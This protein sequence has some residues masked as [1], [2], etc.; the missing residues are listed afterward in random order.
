[1][2]SPFSFSPAVPKELRTLIWLLVGVSLGAALLDP[3]FEEWLQV[4]GPQRLLSLSWGSLRSGFIWQPVTYLFVLQESGALDLIVFIHLFFSAYILYMF[5]AALMEA[6]GVWPVLRMMALSGVLAGLA[7]AAVMGLTGLDYFIA[8]PTPP[9]FACLLCWAML[10]PEAELLLFFVIP[11]LAR[12]LVAGVLA[13]SILI[14]LSQAHWA[15]LVYYIVGAGTGYLYAVMAWGWRSPFVVTHEWDRA[16]FARGQKI[17]GAYRARWGGADQNAKI[18][19]FRT[20]RAVERDNGFMD[21]MLDK[22]NREGKGSLTWRER[23]R[24]LRISR[25]KKAS[26]DRKS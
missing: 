8:G 17:R 3:V 21:A 25:K 4:T 6:A 9:L 10:H 14:S 13:M 2:S 24:M 12:W 22:M 18:F 7:S 20:G 26:S 1:M 15:A 23:W 19:D 5:G 11:V 16:L